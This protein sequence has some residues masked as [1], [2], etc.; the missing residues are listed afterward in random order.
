VIDYDHLNRVIR[1]QIRRKRVRRYKIEG[2]VGEGP[3]ARAGREQTLNAFY[4]KISEKVE[5]PHESLVGV[6]QFLL[7]CL[8]RSLT[9]TVAAVFIAELPQALQQE[10]VELS[11]G[12]DRSIDRSLMTHELSKRFGLSERTAGR[13][14][15]GFFPI[16]FN[17]IGREE[18]I[19]VISQLPPD[20]QVLFKSKSSHPRKGIAA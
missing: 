3:N 14:L 4:K 11:A 1:A 9:Y 7:G 8:I 20:F 15:Q 6:T 19:S 2:S 16:L 18:M 13:I 12:P 17:L 10:L 5:V